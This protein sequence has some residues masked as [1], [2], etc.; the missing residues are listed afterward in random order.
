MKDFMGFVKPWSTGFVFRH[1]WRPW[2]PRS[3]RFRQEPL[4][5]SV[6]ARL[7][8]I[9][10]GILV[11]FPQPEFSPMLIAC[12]DSYP[13]FATESPLQHSQPEKS[14]LADT[15]NTTNANSPSANSTEHLTNNC[16]QPTRRN[17][18]KAQGKQNEV[19]NTKEVY[20]EMLR[21]DFYSRWTCC[22]EL[23]WHQG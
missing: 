14:T 5:T 1:F 22:F 4:M 20:T 10:A 9:E 13:Q 11:P 18:S 6:K 16:I 17:C 12:S 21:G 2:G 23:E 3:G 7:E 15:A 19:N 8:A